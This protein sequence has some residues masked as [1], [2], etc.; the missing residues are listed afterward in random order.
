M[1]NTSR[2][3]SRSSSNVCNIISFDIPRIGV[4]IV[5]LSAATR[6]K[7]TKSE[8]KL[9]IRH[10]VF[11]TTEPGHH[12]D[13][14]IYSFNF[15]KRL[16]KVA[17]ENSSR[18]ENF[19]LPQCFAFVNKSNN[20]DLPVRSSLFQFETE[21]DHRPEGVPRRGVPRRCRNQPGVPRRCRDRPGV[22]R[23]HPG[24]RE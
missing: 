21:E 23:R 13:P 14:T 16:R 24:R 3:V 9:F 20:C 4:H 18:S 11:P 10:L 6:R 12:L 17:F 8:R 22:P 1:L 19:K 15:K 2:E 7:V 5:S